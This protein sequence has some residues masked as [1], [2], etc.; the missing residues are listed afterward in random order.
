MMGEQLR[1]WAKL[2]WESARAYAAFLEYR[3]LHR[4]RTL[5]KALANYRHVREQ[6]NSTKG[7]TPKLFR[8]TIFDRPQRGPKKVILPGYWIRW[9]RRYRWR[10]RAAAWDEHLAGL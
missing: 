4:G 6:Q 5:W 3:D 1:P 7:A 9:A 10:K 8:G 2:S